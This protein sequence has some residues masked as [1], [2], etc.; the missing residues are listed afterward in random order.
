MDRATAGGVSA[1]RRFRYLSIAL[2][3]VALV[4]AACGGSGDDDGAGGEG[5]GA[6]R[7]Q[8]GGSLVYGIEA[9]TA[10]WAPAEGQ[11]SASS[12]VVVSALYDTLMY[13]DDEHDLQ[14]YLA[15][16]MEPNEDHTA[17]TLKLRPDITF[18]NGDALD[19]DALIRNMEAQQASPL[20][21]LV[22]GPVTAIEKVDDLTV[23]F[24][25]ANSWVQFP[26]I[27]A[28]QIGMM[29]APEMLDSPDGSRNPIGT[30]PFAFETWTP[31]ASLEVVAYPDYWAGTPY[32]NEI[33]YRI[34]PDPVTRA[35]ALTT[36]EIDASLLSASPDA[37][38]MVT[39]SEGIEVYRAPDGEVTEVFLVLNQQ[40][41]PWDDPELRRAL[42]MATNTELM[43]ETLAEGLY[44]PAEGIW[45]PS[46]PWYVETDY[47]EFDPE[48]AAE[49]VASWEEENG[50]EL[51]IELIGP[52][53]PI[54]LEGGQLVEQ[55]WEEIGVDVEIQTLELTQ[56]ILR[57]VTGDFEGAVWQYHDSP[58]PDGEFVFL[59]SQYIR[60]SPGISLNFARND[61]P[62]ID[63]ALLEARYTEDEARQRELYGQ[64][65][66]E[67][68]E[69]LPYVFFWHARDGVAAADSVHGILD[70]TLPDGQVGLGMLGTRHRFHQIWV[71]Q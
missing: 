68:A 5:D 31:D 13:F 23:R 8:S 4:A 65:Q 67:M 14:P 35:M 33:E 26:Y 12:W 18:H 15:E 41:E 43:V 32:L 70:W 59:H 55:M 3:A 44:E 7:P 2:V 25:L 52:P 37:L 1:H 9:E 62:A 47:P 56:H 63:E 39:E 58:H 11:W 38:G 27:L 53:W 21:S 66:E 45:A 6:A 28:S 16:S 49:I 50:E 17:W 20:T 54:V 57:V 46:S 34:I 24:E 30:G 36:G 48:A 61:N 71:E 51:S 40:Q 60:P 42:V 64:V 22:L 10:S 19:S 69:D 29:A